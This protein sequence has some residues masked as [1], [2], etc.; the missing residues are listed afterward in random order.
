MQEK[1]QSDIFGF[2]NLVYQNYPK[3]F[4]DIEDK[5]ND[6]YFPNIKVNVKSNVELISTGSI[7]NTIGKEESK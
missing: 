1:Y 3:S 2:G 5:W 6:K 7:E 4:K